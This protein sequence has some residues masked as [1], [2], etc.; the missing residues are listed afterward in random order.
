MQS[1]YI[2]VRKHENDRTFAYSWSVAELSPWLS[3][4]SPVPVFMGFM[5]DKV[6]MG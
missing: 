5:V 4:F 3:G 1:V 6:T 2:G